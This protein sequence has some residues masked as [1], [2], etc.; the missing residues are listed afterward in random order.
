M[1]GAWNGGTTSRRSRRGGVKGDLGRN[2]ADGFARDRVGD[3]FGDRFGEWVDDRV[4]E[5]SSVSHSWDGSSMRSS[6]LGDGSIGEGSSVSHSWDGTSLRSSNLG[7]GSIGEGSSV[8]HS[9]DGSSL[10]SSSL[11]DGSMP[12]CVRGGPVRSGGERR[13]RSV[14]G[15]RIDQS[16]RG[17]SR[18]L[19]S[20]RLP[21]SALPNSI[22]LPWLDVSSLAPTH[23]ARWLLV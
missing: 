18:P 10:R 20:S 6:N 15:V 12:V 7:D 2:E 9:W 14:G 19:G 23:P 21:G 17:E 3:R 1:N 16:A 11:G 22:P 4:G 13:E 5:G 8:P